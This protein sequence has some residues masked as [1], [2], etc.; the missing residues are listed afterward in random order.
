MFIVRNIIRI[1]GMRQPVSRHSSMTKDHD[2]IPILLVLVV[3][4]GSVHHRLPRD[5]VGPVGMKLEVG[6]DVM[7]A[8][9]EVEGVPGSLTGR[10]IPRED[11]MDT[12]VHQAG[13]VR[14]EGVGKHGDSVDGGPLVVGYGMISKRR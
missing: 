11:N 3:V 6:P 2:P 4:H 12:R 8:R 14:Q 7:E 9:G 10:L 13:L 5:V 1:V